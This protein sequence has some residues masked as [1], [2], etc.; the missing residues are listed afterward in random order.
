MSSITSTRQAA[1]ITNGMTK[2]PYFENSLNEIGQPLSIRIF[3]HIIPAR[4]PI[5][6]RFAPKLLPRISANIEPFVAA[7]GAINRLFCRVL[8]NNMVIG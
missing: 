7:A 3:P 6:V 4:A 2:K 5:M 8:V 1:A